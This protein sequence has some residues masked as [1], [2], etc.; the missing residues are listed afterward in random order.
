[1]LPTFLLNYKFSETSNI[2]VV[3]RTSTNPPSVSQLQNVIDNSN[4][5]LLSTGNQNL[6]QNYSHFGM[7]RFGFTNTKKAQSFFA[8]V[9]VNYTQNY[10]GNSTLIAQH[11]TLLN[12]TT[13]LRAGSQLTQPVNL[14]DGNMNANT[15]FT[16]GLPINKI[17]CN[18]NLNAGLSYTRTPSL[19]NN[20]ENLSNSYNVNAGFVLGSNI[21]EKIDFTISYSANYNVVKNSLQKKSDNNYFT[22]NANIKFNWLFWKGFVFNTSLQ[23]TFYTGVSQGFNQDIFL[24][25]ISLGYKFLK[26]KSLEVKAGVS[27]V[28]NQNSSIGRTVS[29]TYVEDSKTQVLKR[30]LMMTVTY[31]LRYFKK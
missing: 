11:D 23:N 1:M 19:I 13:F 26:D 24:W 10:I 27:D 14:K 7:V 16:Y 8:F 29:D 25:N 31:T 21:S 4:P 30:Y 3:Y 5:L 22:H 28:L 12:G 15:F 6:K 17:K 20:A 18:L 9:S 2:R